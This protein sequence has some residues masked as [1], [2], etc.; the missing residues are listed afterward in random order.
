MKKILGPGMVVHAFHP[1]IQKA[2]PYRSLS[3]RSS[4]R[5]GSLTAKI[6]EQKAGDNVVAQ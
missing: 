4:Y 5:E 6:R 1:S 3:S 2:E